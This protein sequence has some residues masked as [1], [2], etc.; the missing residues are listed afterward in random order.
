[1]RLN[2]RQLVMYYSILG[3]Y[4]AGDVAYLLSIHETA[5]GKQ[6]L[7][8]IRTIPLGVL[9]ASDLVPLDDILRDL[10]L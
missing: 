2:G 1:M 10:A 7:A 6:H 9:V 5:D 8:G 3:R 4:R